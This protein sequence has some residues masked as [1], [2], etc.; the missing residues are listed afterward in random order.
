MRRRM[1]DGPERQVGREAACTAEKELL[2]P[3]DE[4]SRFLFK[5]SNHFPT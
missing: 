3:K 4:T 2:E 5:V 1:V